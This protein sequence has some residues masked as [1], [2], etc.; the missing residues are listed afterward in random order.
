MPLAPMASLALLLLAVPPFAQPGPPPERMTPAGLTLRALFSARIIQGPQGIAAKPLFLIE[1]LSQ[2]GTA[3]LRDAYAYRAGPA[4]AVAMLLRNPA[5]ATDWSVER[6]E[7]R[8]VGTGV[9]LPWPQ[10]WQARPMGAEE[11]EWVVVEVA[12]TQEQA[13]ATYV[14]VLWPAG[15]LPPITL[16]G[17]TFP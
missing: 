12:A 14:L 15:G 13:R 3:T 6:A 5:G 11:K 8:E 16:A 10:V 9:A 4:V 7:V 1:A 2:E 17:V